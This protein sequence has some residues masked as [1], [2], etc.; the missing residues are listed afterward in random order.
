MNQARYNEGKALGEELR[1]TCNDPPSE[2]LDDPDFCDGLDSEVFHCDECGW[3]CGRSSDQ[4]EPVCF[5][6]ADED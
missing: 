2:L 3:W 6:C 5:D 1:G 4:D